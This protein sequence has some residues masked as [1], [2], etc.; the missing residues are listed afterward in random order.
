[1]NND[2]NKVLILGYGEMGHALEYLLQD[3]CQLNIWQRHPVNDHCTDNLAQAARDCQLVLYCIPAIPVYSL[4]KQ[5]KPLIDPI[6]PS[7]CIAKGLDASGRPALEAM[8][9]GYN[10]DHIRG[11]LYG[12]MISEEIV[13][14]KPAFAQCV[15]N[16]ADAMTSI[17]GLFQDSTLHLTPCT[18]A[19]GLSWSVILKNVYAMGFGI[20]DALQFGDNVRG[21]L[22][23]AALNE[24]QEI[25]TTLGGDANTVMG[26][27]GLGDLIT[28]ATSKGSHH[29]A[30][31][32][33]I[34]NGEKNLSGEGLHTLNMIVQHQ[35]L[36][37]SD[38]P[39][40]SLIN[41]LI[42]NDQDIK[43]RVEEYLYG[44]GI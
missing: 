10:D 23:S 12:P 16:N 30:L 7:L 3:R 33:Q 19:R 2:I 37:L 34:V 14:G 21:Y 28:T 6:V 1:M 13:A 38:Y 40:M 39:L 29:Y 9:Q 35:L 22:A 27:G 15:V 36:S 26:L 43:A 42:S 41:G 25:V 24:M 31:G 8:A 11:A 18:D 20:C 4:A 44:R 17:F 32:F 5:L